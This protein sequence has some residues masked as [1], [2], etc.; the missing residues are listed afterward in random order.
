MLK[1]FGKCFEGTDRVAS[2]YVAYMKFHKDML[3]C[4][5]WSNE[6]HDCGAMTQ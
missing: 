3:R 4:V 2:A 6:R 5:M 1:V